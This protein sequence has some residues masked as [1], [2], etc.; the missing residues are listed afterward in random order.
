MKLTTTKKSH[1]VSVCSV[2]AI[3]VFFLIWQG[4]KG[5]HL[6]AEIAKE[7]KVIAAMEGPKREAGGN[8]DGVKNSE[9]GGTSEVALPQ[10]N[11]VTVSEFLELIPDAPSKAEQGDLFRFLPEILDLLKEYSVDE[12]F[13]L[14]EEAE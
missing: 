8:K 5:S 2:V 3:C 6:K 9:E 4:K 10:A 1:W 11:A 13:V 7:R 12:L 14:L